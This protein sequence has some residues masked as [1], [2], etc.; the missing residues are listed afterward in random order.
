M[1]T[2]VRLKCTL[3]LVALFLGSH[4]SFCIETPRPKHTFPLPPLPLFKQSQSCLLFLLGY[5]FQPT[6]TFCFL[7]WAFCSCMLS[8]LLCGFKNPLA[9]FQRAWIEHFLL[10]LPTYVHA[11]NSL[12]P[13]LTMLQRD[14]FDCHCLLKPY[15]STR[16]MTTIQ[17]C[18]REAIDLSTYSLL[19]M[20]DET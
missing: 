4:N 14:T 8:H 5:E 13:P 20:V 12:S 6:C 9:D 1:L 18:R 7:D 2:H 16:H 19:C 3:L 10:P 15:L 11:Q 17:A